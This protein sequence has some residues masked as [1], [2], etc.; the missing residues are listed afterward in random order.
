[1]ALDPKTKNIIIEYFRGKPEVATVYLYGSQ[2]RGGAR[3]GSD[4]DLAVLVTDKSKYTGF[5]IVQVVFSQ[6]L[7]KLTKKK[8]GVQDLTSVVVDFAQRV[9]AE[10]KLLISNNERAR[11]DFEEKNFRN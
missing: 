3:L 7:E 1:M 11:I 5:R 9:L 6:D 4:I 10:G 8:V 2:A